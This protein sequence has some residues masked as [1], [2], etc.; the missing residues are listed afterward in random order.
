MSIDPSGEF[1]PLGSYGAYGTV[2]S[3]INVVFCIGLVSFALVVMLTVAIPRGMPVW[4][5]GLVL[6]VEA[7]L[8][9]R[10]LLIARGVRRR[11]REAEAGVGPRR[12]Q[13]D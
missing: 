5:C 3:V 13:P 4:F 1:G 8:V 11:E 2:G 7:F 9:W 12:E 10:F 6:V